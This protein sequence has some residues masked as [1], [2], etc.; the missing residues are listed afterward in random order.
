MKL[1]IKYS[2]RLEEQRIE[3][4]IK[5]LPWYNKLGYRPH[6]PKNI[7]P[8]IDNLKKINI[9]LKNEYNEKDYKNAKNKILKKNSVIG[10][11]F[12]SNLENICGKKAKKEYELILTKY[13]VG[14][15]YF[16]PN[17]IIINI[18][19]K[20]KIN[21]ILHEITHL[22]IESNIQK[23]KIEQNQKERIIDLILTSKQISLDNYKMQKR[24]KE[25][26][27]TIDKLFKKYFKP[28]LSNF[29]KKLEKMNKTVNK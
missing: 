9:A 25:H 2:I 5:K 1:N 18:N 27:K 17:Q 8:E 22:V 29:F 23:Y 20:S 21:T 28:P 24:G 4:T 3:K 10:K 13:G 6:F 11:K 14:G 19:S 15:S 12:I 7:N 26:K 16:L